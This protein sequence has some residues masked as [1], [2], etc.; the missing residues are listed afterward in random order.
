MALCIRGS[1]KSKEGEYGLNKGKESTF[2][3]I[4]MCFLHR[5]RKDKNM[6][7]GMEYAMDMCS[8]S[9]NS[10]VS[11]TLFEDIREW[12]VSFGL[13]LEIRAFSEKYRFGGGGLQGHGLLNCPG[14]L[15]EQKR[16]LELTRTVQR[17]VMV[18]FLLMLL[19]LEDIL[20]AALRLPL[21]FN[22]LH[23]AIP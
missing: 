2:S 20:S 1:F 5:E 8:F 3:H 10:I 9:K 17:N 4:R 11:S 15:K 21:V 18:T 12:N 14:A 7:E 6:G 16:T 22:T 13:Q 19:L 23:E